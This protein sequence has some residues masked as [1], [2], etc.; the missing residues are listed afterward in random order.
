MSDRNQVNE[1]CHRFYNFRVKMTRFLNFYERILPKCKMGELSGNRE[2]VEFWVTLYQMKKTV[3]F[4]GKL[5]MQECM[6]K[7]SQHAYLSSLRFRARHNFITTLSFLCCQKKIWVG[8]ECRFYLRR[9]FS[10]NFSIKH[11]LPSKHLILCQ[12]DVNRWGGLARKM[13]TYLRVRVNEAELTCIDN[14]RPDG[15]ENGQVPIYQDLTKSLIP[16]K[17]PIW[18]VKL[19]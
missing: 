10:L 9:L 2:N 5:C 17:T 13:W 8:S 11:A 18:M 15:L 4:V 1:R 19:G 3:S 16:L 12:P 7:Y 6:R 14:F